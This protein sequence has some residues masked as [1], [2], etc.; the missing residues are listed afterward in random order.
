[1]TIQDNFENPFRK[2]LAKK[3]VLTGIWSMLNS[4]N[5]I[6]GLGW[7]GFDW[8]VIDAEHSPVSLHDAMAHLRALSATPT[9]PVV[10]LPW[11][12]NVLIK[13]YL[14]IGAQTIMLPLVQNAKEAQAAVSAMRYPPG[15]MR[16]FA[17]MHR[18]SRYGHLPRY[19]ERAEETLFAIVQ[20]ETVEALERLDE[21]ASVDGVD[22]VFFGPGDLSASMGLLGKPDQAEVF[23]RIVEASRT[24]QKLGKS[25]GVLAPNTDHARRY[26]GAGVNFVSVATDCAL[27]FRNADALAADFAA[28]TAPAK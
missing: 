10:R 25:T 9:I 27:L 16:G 5:V 6:E 11:N 19:V 17:A 15:G 23:D 26:C 4:T 13:H 2:A 24:V 28:I 1:M 7:A 12:D 18:A 3:E 21:I 8:L 22:A 14:D 20:V